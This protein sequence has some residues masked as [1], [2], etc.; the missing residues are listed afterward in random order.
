MPSK[1][2]FPLTVC[3]RL[4]F[5][6]EESRLA[7]VLGSKNRFHYD[8]IE[9]GVSLAKK[10][11]GDYSVR[12]LRRLFLTTAVVANMTF[13]TGLASAQVPSS[14]SW[15][16]VVHA[17]SDAPAVDVL[18]N[19]NLVFQGLKFKDYTEYTPVPPGT[20]AFQVNLSGTGTTAV[21]AGPT[22]LQGGMAYTFYALGKASAN[23]LVIMATGDDVAAP[24]SGSTKVR[25]VHGASTAPAVDVYA[26]APYAPLPSA[27]ALTAVPFPLAG[28]YLTVPAGVYQ[29]R[30]TVAGT[31]TVAI[32]SGRLP[33]TGGT[34]RTVVALDPDRAGEPFQLL[35]LPDV[36]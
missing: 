3:L 31:R 4:L 32:D 22:T 7:P 25:V 34:V 20:Y 13:V 26:S 14:T 12:M 18:A 15:V 5:S 33:L 16:R 1:S 27:P 19:G 17:A 21:S 23:S 30:V 2:R 36:N 24:P 28:P 11:E 35:V 6:F 10:L 9:A 29:A 8:Q